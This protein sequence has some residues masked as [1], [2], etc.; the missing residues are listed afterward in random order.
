LPFSSKYEN[1][2][3]KIWIRIADYMKTLNMGYFSGVTLRKKQAVT[4]YSKNRKKAKR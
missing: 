4:V 3:I 2:N 1:T